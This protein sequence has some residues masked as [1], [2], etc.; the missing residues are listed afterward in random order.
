MANKMSEAP[1]G[2]KIVTRCRCNVFWQNVITNL[3]K[4]ECKELVVENFKSFNTENRVNKGQLGTLKLIYT[5]QTCEV[6]VAEELQNHL[7]IVQPLSSC[8]T[9]LS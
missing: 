5:R 4:S 6:L 3:S 8:E 7:T 1:S 2:I 9:F